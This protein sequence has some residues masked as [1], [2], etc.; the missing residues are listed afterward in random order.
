[1]APTLFIHFDWFH[2]AAFYNGATNQPAFVADEARSIYLV[3]QPY[4]IFDATPGKVGPS[5]PLQDYL[6]WSG[7]NLGDIA[8]LDQ[9]VT[10]PK[11]RIV[12]PVPF[13]PGTQLDLTAS[14]VQAG[15]KTD[16][17]PF[18]R[19]IGGATPSPPLFAFDPDLQSAWPEFVA[20]NLVPVPVR[21][22]AQL[23]LSQKSEVLSWAYDRAVQ[24]RRLLGH[25]P[26]G[27]PAPA[28]TTNPALFAIATEINQRFF[29]TA[30]P[31]PVDDFSQAQWNDFLGSSLAPGSS[32]VAGMFE[33]C[34]TKL[35]AGLLV[36]S[37][38]KEFRPP[39]YKHTITLGQTGTISSK[40]LFG[41]TP[42][43]SYHELLWNQLLATY[44]QSGDAN[45]AS[46]RLQEA[47]QRL[48]VFGERLQWPVATP[49]AAPDL[50]IVTKN[51]DLGPLGNSAPDG[52]GWVVTNA[53]S[54]LGQVFRFGPLV[55][56][57]PLDRFDITSFAVQT[58]AL[59]AS[60][61]GQGATWLWRDVLAVNA[62]KTSFQFDIKRRDHDSRVFFQ[63]KNGQTRSAGFRTPAEKAVNS[64]DAWM[65]QFDVDTQAIPGGVLDVI[66]QM[67]R[68]EFPPADSYQLRFGDS[69]RLRRETSARMFLDPVGELYGPGDQT[70]EPQ[71]PKYQQDLWRS[72]RALAHVKALLDRV[73]LSGMDGKN[74]GAMYELSLGR[75]LHPTDASTLHLYLTEVSVAPPAPQKRRAALWLHQGGPTGKIVAFDLGPNSSWDDARGVL[76]I[77][78]TDGSLT[79]QLP[80]VKASD[81]S[82]PPAAE[83]IVDLVID[84]DGTREP[85]NWLVPIVDKPA[86]PLIVL[87]HH[88]THN[89]SRSIEQLI[90]DYVVSPV[91]TNL[92][93]PPAAHEPLIG[94]VANFNKLR[95]KLA[96]NGTSPVW[97]TY[98]DALLPVS[99]TPPKPIDGRPFPTYP[100]ALQHQFSQQVTD[101]PKTS[102]EARYQLAM[103]PG[104]SWDL[105]GT[106]E[107]QYGHWLPVSG[108]KVAF[109]RSTDVRDLASVTFWSDAD[110]KAGKVL[111][112]LRFDVRP[113]TTSNPRSA[114][115]QL[116]LDRAYFQSA[117]AQYGAGKKDDDLRPGSLRELY[118]T[119]VDLRDAKSA[120]LKI[121]RW[122]FDNTVNMASPSSAADPQVLEANPALFD[123]MRYLETGTFP[124]LAIPTFQTSVL[125]VLLQEKFSDFVAKLTT[126]VNDPSLLWDESHPT[127]GLWLGLDDP[128]WTW[129]AAAAAPAGDDGTAD[130]YRVGIAVERDPQHTIQKDGYDVLENLT[131]L[132]HQSPDP[133]ASLQ[134]PDLAKLPPA[135]LADFRKY[136]VDN[137]SSQM[138]SP[139]FRTFDWIITRDLHRDSA[140]PPPERLFGDL[141]PTLS[142]ASRPAVA[143]PVVLYY[144]PYDFRPLAA[145]PKFGDTETTEE[146]AEYLLQILD[147][148]INGRALTRVGVLPESLEE[149]IRDRDRARKIMAQGG[150]LP[151]VARQLMQLVD[152]VEYRDA[153]NQY[154]LAAAVGQLADALLPPPQ[155]PPQT[156]PESW[157]LGQALEALFAADP[158]LYATTKAIGVGIFEP[159][160]FSNRLHSLQLSKHLP[161]SSLDGKA[162][163]DR[164]RFIFPEV[165][166]ADPKAPPQSPPVRFFVDIL[167]E[168][169]YGDQFQITSA[170][171]RD[172]S[173]LVEER[174][175]FDSPYNATD[176][177]TLQAS[178][179]FY[180]PTWK[181]ASQKTDPPLY[182][183]PSRR[184]PV[185]PKLV[186]PVS[187]RVSRFILDIP[188]SEAESDLDALYSSVVDR[189][190]A[191]AMLAS[192]TP[193][194]PS[195]KVVPF[196]DQQQKRHTQATIRSALDKGA[197]FHTEAYLSHYYFIVETDESHSTQNDLFEIQTNLVDSAPGTSAQTS[198]LPPMET[199]L[200]KW[201]VYD[202]A[203]KQGTTEGLKRPDSLSLTTI[204]DEADGW[205]RNPKAGT[206]LL[207]ILPMNQADHTPH[208]TYQPTPPDGKAVLERNGTSGDPNDVGSVFAA[209]LFRFENDDPKSLS[210]Y[211]LHL[212]IVDEPW[213]TTEVRVRLRRN[214]V[215]AQPVEER[216]SVDTPEFN[217]DMERATKFTDWAGYGRAVM[218]LSASDLRGLAPCARQIVPPLLTL[219]DW[220]NAG[221]NTPKSF[222]VVP[223]GDVRSSTFKIK[224][225]ARLPF[226]NFS[227][228]LSP[229]N[230]VSGVV[231]Q[232]IGD[233]HPR[234]PQPSAAKRI[235]AERSERKT[236]QLLAPEVRADQLEKLTSGILKGMVRTISPEIGVT[237][238]NGHHEPLL[239]VTWPVMFKP[240]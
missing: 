179:T 131:P 99:Q 112:A 135:A 158:G 74:K 113:P 56:D 15:A 120:V 151:S 221:E 1:M 232:V 6:Q 198:D 88:F 133:P 203:K 36:D 110:P 5:P 85:F 143:K 146:F 149:A 150:T 2:A 140:T 59:D 123:H 24:V 223:A 51:D 69:P 161:T 217:P 61:V 75:D 83:A 125:D 185:I 98:P 222:G 106:M 91:I 197:W 163:E 54:L 152:R 79:D 195:L 174:N 211:V 109:H 33:L 20:R 181:A 105:Q 130:C 141:T 218:A 236:R 240:H 204:L 215:F 63:P 66:E 190:P 206:P 97:L 159:G 156:P 21:V 48:F 128:R 31:R 186:V 107:H 46:A 225:G 76:V 84:V 19:V 114:R 189:L 9:N 162:L 38:L 228:A 94:Q 16:A 172:A 67:G 14:W 53:H 29:E 136:L 220:M 71:D 102:E 87:K 77:R 43:R 165:L 22:H 229:I 177:P 44:V 192:H 92:P 3:A 126:F 171:A 132:D 233:L 188:D 95:L 117:L 58:R 155:P 178:V 231:Q 175:L 200:Q 13:P 12:I 173:D 191:S 55:G 153:L 119:L 148:I 139:L 90:D 49:D 82:T 52:A 230:S 182:L 115:I 207:Q 50:M 28:P 138:L 35:T 104:L 154:P 11:S 64:A 214:A 201:F 209:E 7:A 183:L 45:E 30:P 134:L 144:V 17:K 226:W 234:E 216:A 27:A 213:F 127:N 108:E 187:D 60:G 176:P 25:A 208:Y 96:A 196:V 101:T 118:E 37:A 122:S 70:V 42:R 23:S 164:D 78:D 147:D 210:K 137:P 142:L 194:P 111:H 81:G 160:S 199:P 169:Q 237:W 10:L 40:D 4:L 93:T 124:V 34:W 62:K 57:R 47:L 224:G 39:R 238:F 86:S 65:K 219:D 202:R 121:E 184:F 193:E 68:V 32:R 145:H 239:S 212:A 227:Q 26:T 235:I 8:L 157:P 100:Y 170:R 167:D 180:N 18:Q 73:P 205:L 129:T 80:K 72:F 103:R 116:M 41:A 168:A 89:V 166:P